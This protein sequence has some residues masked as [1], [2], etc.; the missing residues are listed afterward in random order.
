MEG[1]VFEII[2][3]ERREAARAAVAAAFGSTP[4]A[5]SPI[6]GGASALTYRLEVAGRPYVLRLEASDGGLRSAHRSFLCMGIAAEAGVA[7]ALHHADAESGVAIM[8]CIPL[9]P[10]ASYPDG[11][12]G[13]VRGVGELIA[14]L[15]GAPAFPEAGD[16][17]LIIERILGYVTGSALFAPGLLDPHLAKFEQVRAAYPWGSSAGVSASND[18]NA[19]NVL[20]DGERLWLVDWELAFR[21]DPLVDVAILADN[22]AQ[23]PELAEVLLEAWLGRPADTLTRARFTLMRPITRL[24]Y[25]AIIFS[26][27]AG[28][29]PPTPETDLT[30]L[31]PAEL[32]AAVAEGRLSNAGPDTLFALGKMMLAGFLSG[33]A[34][35]GFEE[36]MA[37][38]RSG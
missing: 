2:P 4:N 10:L 19:R 35:P 27:F 12:A 28:A 13:I 16:Y 9:K 36:A 25:A 14:R 7:P 38:A 37:V 15:Q 32:I 8:D 34:A 29:P 24:F 3:A 17:A 23:A 21:N 5:L 33:C 26:R 11:P 18:P 30:P 22:F 20:Y 6:S 31:T 1:A